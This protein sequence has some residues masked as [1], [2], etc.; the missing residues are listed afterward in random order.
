M[1][2]ILRHAEITDIIQLPTKELN[3]VKDQVIYFV[4]GFFFIILPVSGR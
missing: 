4:F 2:T 1:D 3:C